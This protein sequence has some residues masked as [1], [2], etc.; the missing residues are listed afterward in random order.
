[1]NKHKY[2]L[3]LACIGMILTSC[4]ESF[5][6]TEPLTSVTTENYYKTIDDAERALIACYDGWQST[7]SNNGGYAFYL[8][9]EVMADECFG[10]TGN[11]DTKEFQT[12]DRFD[13]S[14]SSSTMSLFNINW[15]DGYA[16][17]F[18]CNTLIQKLDQIDWK[19]DDNIR[20]R[21]EGET[22][23][24]RALL[25]F[26]LV[27]MFGNIPLLEEPTEE[28]IP[29]A[30]PKEVYALIVEDLKFTANNLPANAYPKANAS[31][32]DGRI[33]SYAAKALLARVYL[34][35]TGYYGADDLGISA[36][37]ALAGL[38]DIISSGEYDLVEEFKNLWPAASS[39]PVNGELRFETTYA[40]DGNIET[41][42]AQKFNTTHDYDGNLDG[43][44][45]LVM[46]GMRETSFSPYGQGWGA[47]PVN[48]AI[49]NAFEAGDARKT[50][51]IIDVR[52]EGIEPSYNIPG[53]REYTGFMVKK[54]T[55]M[56]F[57]DGTSASKDDGSGNFQDNQHQD[58]VVVRYADVLLMAAE[59]GSS[60]A[61]NYFDRVR[62]RAGL[63]P[64]AVSKENILR[65]RYFEFAFEGLR[66]WDLLRQGV[67]YAAGIIAEAGVDVLSGGN[68]D[69]VTIDAAKI[70]AS[71]GLCQIPKTQIDLSQG[72]LKQNEGW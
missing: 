60:N 71:K 22:R 49:W 21:I 8:A 41:V 31:Q 61:Q 19:G 58:F 2:I 35:Y 24:L 33:T 13:I 6:D 63:S 69:Q 40:G 17:I 4:S 10:G 3:L 51:S 66:Y 9:S 16:G 64:K 50:A 43:N 5:L 26:D 28:N 67:D 62:L 57:Y 7:S 59:L 25:Y 32:N 46:M 23:A 47:C 38:E 14:F 27:R 56:A 34:Y 70:R 54:Y 52:G 30:D 48:P 12:I 55:P 68:P 15:T 39:S 42:L 29:Q 37:E 11:N 53:Q 18:R 45:W 36:S 72:V 20:N 1:M 65:E 44:R